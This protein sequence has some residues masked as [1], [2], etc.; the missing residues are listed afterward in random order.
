MRGVRISF[1]GE[2]ITHLNS[3]QP[4]VTA[5]STGT[6]LETTESLVVMRSG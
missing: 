1:G 3:S 5:E 2:R 6:E 4:D